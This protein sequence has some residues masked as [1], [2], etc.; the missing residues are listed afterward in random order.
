VYLTADN[1]RFEGQKVDCRGRAGAAFAFAFAE[2]IFLEVFDGHVVTKKQDR[3]RMFD[4]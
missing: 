2:T 1:G 3:K 4:S